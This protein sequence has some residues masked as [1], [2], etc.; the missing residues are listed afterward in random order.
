MTDDYLTIKKCPECNITYADDKYIFCPYCGSKLHIRYFGGQILKYTADVII[1]LSILS[2]LFISINSYSEDL[3]NFCVSEGYTTCESN[4]F[5]LIITCCNDT[6]CS[7]YFN[8]LM[9]KDDSSEKYL[10]L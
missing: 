8:Q 5:S 2:F 10:R 6:D 1:G 3:D 4:A 7:K 9:E